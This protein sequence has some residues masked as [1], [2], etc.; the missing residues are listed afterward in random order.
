MI[1]GHDNYVDKHRNR[2]LCGSIL[3]RSLRWRVIHQFPVDTALIKGSAIKSRLT[4]NAYSFETAI[5]IFNQVF[6]GAE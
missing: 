5:Y 6:A 3:L 4:E 1:N 2:P